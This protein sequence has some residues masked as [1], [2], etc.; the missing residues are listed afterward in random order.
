MSLPRSVPGLAV[1]LALGLVAAFALD[2]FARSQQP[3]PT[4]DEPPPPPAAS[5]LAALEKT[6]K[7]ELED[8]KRIK[9][10]Q[11]MAGLPGGSD[12][13]ARIVRGTNRMTSPSPPR[14]SCGASPWAT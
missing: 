4:D 12:A 10:A 9:L 14:T 7:A 8:K 6:Y 5:D 1:V 11:Q 2:P 3:A 13:L